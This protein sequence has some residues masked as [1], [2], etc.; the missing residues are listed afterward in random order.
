MLT[1][2]VHG[3]P[4]WTAVSSRSCKFVR[5]A[6]EGWS[7]IV[8]GLGRKM[9]SDVHCSTKYDQT[10]AQGSNACAA[11]AAQFASSHSTHILYLLPVSLESARTEAAASRELLQSFR[12]PFHTAADRPI[13]FHHPSISATMS[14]PAI[15][16][17]LRPV[18]TA[19]P[20]SFPGFL[21][22]SWSSSAQH[23]CVPKHLSSAPFS[24]SQSLA[25]GKRNRD[26]SKNRGISA[27]RRT[28]LPKRKTLSIPKDEPLPRPVTDP[29]L[30]PKIETDPRHGL[31][32]FF[33]SNEEGKHLKTID[34]LNDHGRSWDMEE[35]RQ[36]SWE[37]LHALWWKCTLERNSLETQ[38]LERI[39]IDIGYGDYEGN[40][41]DKVVCIIRADF[42]AVLQS[43]LTPS[44]TGPRD[45]EGHQRYPTRAL[46]RM[47]RRAQACT[48]R[49]GDRFDH[50]SQWKDTA[51]VHAGHFILVR[52]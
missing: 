10:K 16:Q 44:L 30:L 47:G 49:S 32:G 9:R 37:D 7:K 5:I 19:R 14:K 34:E 3:R 22:P 52:R 18:C 13:G 2:S 29:A 17:A 6:N 46:V 12:L 23:Q 33:A 39:R 42:T 41:R 15:L 26:Y 21:I 11:N 31:W 43:Q 1:G 51:D 35:L 25:K 40:E 48:R 24:T 45:D 8:V 38:R 28:G 50:E 20:V 4:M 36:K 27:I